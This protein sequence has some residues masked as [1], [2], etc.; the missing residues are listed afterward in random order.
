M[1]PEHHH[2]STAKPLEEARWLGF[3][4]M[5]AQTEPPK[6]ANKI[7][8][9]QATPT[10]AQGAMKNPFG[11][12]DFKFTFKRQSLE[13]SPEA[14][15]MMAESRKEAAKIRAQMIAQSDDFA[16]AVGVDTASRKTANPKGKIGRFSDVHM[17]EFKKMDSI[18]NH[19]SAFRTD[20]NKFKLANTSLKRTQSKAE[21]DEPES[22]PRTKSNQSL[23]PLRDEQN[24]GPAKRVKHHEHDDT[25][26]TRPVFRE[27]TMDASKPSTPSGRGLVRPESGLP[28]P[29]SA[30]ATP[31]KASIARSQSVTS[32]RTTMIPSLVRSP[33]ARSFAAPSSKTPGMTRRP[34]SLAR[35]A[36]MKSILRTPQRLYSNDPSKLAA[37]THLAPPKVPVDLNKELPSVPATEP[38]RKHVDF[39]ASTV[40]RATGCEPVPIVRATTAEPEPSTV[41]YPT[42]VA[43][44]PPSRP[45]PSRRTT[46]A[47]MPNDFTFRSDK[48]ISFAPIPGHTVRPVRCSDGFKPLPVLS[49]ATATKR[50]LDAVDESSEQNKE[51]RSDEE[52][53]RPSKKVKASEPEPPKVPVKMS[54]SRLPTRKGQRPG[55]LSQARLNMLA[56]PKKRKV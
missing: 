14:R 44:E 29:T 56:T 47:E 11:S 33:S 2:T 20:P 46:L 53:D 54:A 31:T 50:T 40:A 3:M 34:S 52:G 16:S 37:G 22:I 30:L 23:R 24:G 26:A 45:D 38:V 27:S 7:A 12:P 42:L 18:A 8:A 17:A 15:K 9:A 25:S 13:L 32:L 19:P 1:H 51:N 10:K 36:N 5:G 6:S 49:T 35:F 43:N 21:L 39:T 41:T 55:G 4:N 28:Q 48:P